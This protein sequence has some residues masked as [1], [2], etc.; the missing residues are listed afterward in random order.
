VFSADAE[1]T[2]SR[3]ACNSSRRAKSFEQKKPSREPYLGHTD[4]TKQT[5]EYPTPAKRGMNPGAAK[6]D[7]R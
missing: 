7:W 2:E 1:S 6:E 4:S 5:G 3:A